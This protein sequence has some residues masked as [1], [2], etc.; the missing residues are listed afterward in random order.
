MLRRWADT[1]LPASNEE[2]EDADL[3]GLP[4][5]NVSVENKRAGSVSRK[6]Q[7]QLQARLQ[8]SGQDQFQEA[9]TLQGGSIQD[10]M[11]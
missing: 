2:P 11:F 3:A 8:E 7:F 10:N 4:P 5:N 9:C 6:A 1:G